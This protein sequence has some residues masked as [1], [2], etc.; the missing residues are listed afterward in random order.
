LSSFIKAFPGSPGDDAAGGNKAWRDD[1]LR[2]I[3]S[4]LD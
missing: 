2:V 4:N 3:L 1:A